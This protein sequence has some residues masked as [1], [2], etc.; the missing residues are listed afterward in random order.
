M[1]YESQSQF[2]VP[3]RL[4]TWS[5][6]YNLKYYGNIA[7]KT[8]ETEITGMRYY[9]TLSDVGPVYGTVW[10]EPNNPQDPRARVV[11]RDDGKKIGYLPRYALNEYESFNDKNLVCPFAGRIRVDQRGYMRADI[12]VALPSS[13]EY[14]KEKLSEYLDNSQ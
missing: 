5:F 10:P 8:M 6:L 13:R 1:A 4:L 7:G 3:E 9:C 11:I 12:M 14:V 2:V